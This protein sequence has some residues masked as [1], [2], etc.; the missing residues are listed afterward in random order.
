MPALSG[1]PVLF[2]FPSPSCP[3]GESKKNPGETGEQMQNHK[4]VPLLAKLIRFLFF[5]SLFLNFLHP[6]LIMSSLFPSI[7]PIT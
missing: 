4:L 3:P 2:P 1:V 7:R 6:C 5:R